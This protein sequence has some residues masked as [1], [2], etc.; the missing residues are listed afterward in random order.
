MSQFFYKI[1]LNKY[2]ELKQQIERQKKDFLNISIS[3]FVI[4]AFMVGG[5]FM[6]NGMLEQKIQSRRELLS[7][8]KKEIKSYQ[9]TGEYLS[10]NDLNRIAKVSSERI[11]WAKKLVAFS[12]KTT[13]KIAITHFSFK[14]GKLSLFGI[15][16]LDKN[17]KEFD[18]IDEFIRNLKSNE[19]ISADFPNI[20][21]VKSSTD[22]EKDVEILRFQIDATVK[23]EPKRRK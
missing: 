20:S 19:Q 21:F 4:T 1:N 11:F 12:E 7:K 8:I 17:E 5:L 3:F 2:G 13:D 6:L 15:T 16:K 18:L 23:D 22:F 10:S 9:V 14:N